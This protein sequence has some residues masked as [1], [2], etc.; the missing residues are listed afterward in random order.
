MAESS[1]DVTVT[2]KADKITE[3][4]HVLEFSGDEAVS[5]LYNFNLVLGC[6]SS[7]LDFDKIIGEPA[8]LTINGANG[9]RYVHGMVSR[10]RYVMKGRKHT[11]YQ[12]SLVPRAWRMLHR[13][14]CYMH[15]GKHM[16]QVVEK[17]LKKAKI[18]HVIHA[19]GK[20]MPEKREYCVQYRESNWNF[21]SR[22]LEEEGYCYFFEHK[23]NK[24]VL[25]IAN[26]Y[27]FHPDIAKD[28][29]DST[30]V[31]YHPR[32]AAAAGESIT[33]MEYN[34]EVTAGKVTLQEY[35]FEKPVL[36]LKKDQGHKTDTE[37]EV[38]DYPGL[39]GV[40]E[41]GKELAE[42]RLQEARTFS[43]VASG[44]SDCARFIAGSVF[45]LD[46]FDREAM[47]EKQYMLTRVTHT[48]E[49]H[50]D[51]EAG[52]VSKRIRY[53][54]E[55]SCIPRDKPFRPRRASQKP[56]VQ[57]TQTAVVV[58]PDNEEIYTDEHGRIKV[59]FHWDRKAKEKDKKEKSSCW[60]R[61][62]QMWAGQSWGTMFI[63]RKGMEVVVDFLEGD[64]DRP[65]VIG[66][67]Y[68]A[69]NPP[70]YTLPKN[71]T[72]STIKSRSTTG[73]GGFNEICFEDKKGKEEFFTHA[74]RNRRDV[75]K[76]SH[77]LSVGGSQ[78]RTIGG[79][80][81]VTIKK[82]NDRLILKKGD[83]WTTVEEGAIQLDTDA[84]SIEFHSY[85]GDIIMTASM[86]LNI[87]APTVKLTGGAAGDSTITLDDVGVTIDGKLI[88]LNCSS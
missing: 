54:N 86:E 87:T 75:V 79:K 19:K 5:E 11:V 33:A 12:A 38:Y 83:K 4:L 73:G 29:K 2:F 85:D 84:G 13:Q 81:K 20:K 62:C 34:Q 65:I 88:K 30:T 80:R 49:K 39:Y 18:D 82:G 31:P 22:M 48:G 52:A 36:N 43:K 44:V 10:F 77:S 56:S 47:N 45:T 42:I 28:D 60:I 41:K 24:H 68:H 53:H 9:E 14:D 26:D 59:Q 78:T 27:R 46:K 70:P 21:I 69:Q 61:V 16:L 57:G 66:C 67:V 50:G 37:L 1:K 74:Q 51:L 40:P 6:S 64:P 58:G 55:F 76:R 7:N 25:H 17:L 35:N 23:A 63:P 32:S 15:Q 8:V 72:K 71:K 3:T